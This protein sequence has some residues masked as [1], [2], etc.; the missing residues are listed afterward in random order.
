[1]IPSLVAGELKE[2]IVEYLATTFALTDDEAY[3]ALSDFLL[4]ENDGIFRGPFLRLRLP[5]V[6]APPGSDPGLEWT[7]PGFQP[8]VHQLLAWR[9][10]AGR[11]GAPAS[12]LITTGTG[13]GKSE[14]FL[15][16][17][18]D[19]CR[20]AKQ[21]GQHGIKALILYPMNALVVDQERRIAE[22]LSAPEL[23]AAGVTAGVWIGDDGTGSRH[24]VMSGEHLIN[25]QATLRANP[26]DIL[27][28]NYKM[29]DR[30]LTNENRQALWAKNTRPSSGPDWMQPLQ[31]L[32][33]DEFHT[34][35]GAQGTDVAMLLRRLGH[36]LGIASSTSPL[37]GVACIGTSATLGSAA[38]A[39][40]E[41]RQFAERVFGQDFDDASVIGEQR[42]TVDAV[43]PELDLAMS[44]PAPG[45][46][47]DLDPSDTD[48]L[49]M[50][51]TGIGFDDPQTVGDRLLKHPLTARLLHI[52][53]SSPRSWDDVVVTLAARTPEWSQAA[54][55]TP[56]LVADALERF[57]GLLSIAR[58]RTSSGSV[59]PL[60]AIEVQ[61][62]IREVT[63]ITRSIHRQARFHWADS[64]SGDPNAALELPAVYCTQCGRSGWLGVANR[65]AGTGDLAIERLDP[66]TAADPYVVALRDRDRSR[67]MVRASS[68]EPDVLWLDPD[69]GQV[70]HTDPQSRSIPVLVGGMTG[71][72][73]SGE[74]RDE[75]AK[76]QQCPSCG[77][78]DAM[79]FLG[80]RVT[81]LASVGITQM[82]GS[83]AVADDERRI[84]AF[85]D[86]VQDASHRAAFF[87]GRTHRFNL[88][89][90]LS[91]ALQTKGR[92]ALNDVASTVLTVADQDPKPADAVFSLIPPDLI[93]ED[94]LTDA[95]RHHGSPKAD[96]ARSAIE[97]RLSF[98]AVLEAG[99][100]S[101]LGRTLETT[102]T[103]VPEVLVTD[104]EW[105]HLVDFVTESLQANAG[106]LIVGQDALRPWIHGVIDR[107]R[108]RG[109]IH[110]P[111]LDR[112]V[113]TN[114]KRW[115][116]W[117]GADPI[118]PK[119]PKGISAPSFLSD[120]SSDEFDPIKGKQS[121]MTL[122]A[123][124]LLGVENQPAETV[125]RDL[126]NELTA[127]GIFE[128]R[129]SDKGSV[130]GI[131]QHRIEF[132]DVSPINGAHPQTELRCHVCAHRHYA[133][134]DR[135]DDWLG[136]PCMRSRCGGHLV[137]AALRSTNYYRRLYRGGQIRRVVAA[138]HT[139]LLTQRQ[140]EQIESGFKGGTSPDSPNV[141]AA[142]PTL[143]MGI[144][145]GDLSAVMLTA[146]PPTPANYIQRVGRAGRRTGNAFVTTFAEA[147]PRSQ[148]FMHEP[149]QMIAGDVTAPACFLD[150]I[151]IL[152]RQ[153]VAFL[154]DQAARRG[155]GV[156]PD[157]GEMPFRIGKL[158]SMGLEPDG[159]MTQLIAAGSDTEV[160]G[161]FV[162]LFG[163]HLDKKVILRLGKWA[164]NDLE[165]HIHSR[166]NRWIEQLNDLKRQRDRLRDR[167]KEL[168][169]L[170]N[171]S[172][173][174]KASL[175]RVTS[176]LRYVAGR[177]TGAQARDT[178]GAL[179]ALGIMP[180]Y[181]LFDDTVT[182]EVN[183]WQSNADYDP[184]S[185]GSRKF[186]TLNTE[187]QRAASVAIRE[188]APGNYFYV[189][190]H[191]VRI[192]ALDVGTE[193]EPSHA[194]WRI[195]PVCAWATK[196]VSVPLTKCDR[197]GTPHIADHGQIATVLPMRVV[198]STE[199][200]ATSRVADDT[201]ERDREFHEVRTTI[202][203]DP[204]D[205]EPGS[206]LLHGG[207]VT[208]GVEAARIATIRY[209]N[210]GLQAA[211][212]GI[213]R[214]MM[215]DGREV[216][217]NLFR[218]C[219]HCGGVYGIKGD[220]KDDTDPNHHRT[221]CKVRSGARKERWDHL[222]LV[223]ELTT[224]AVRIL[225]PIGDFESTER[226]QSFKAALML[227][228]RDSFGGD[229]SHLRILETSFP[230]ANNP[231]DR[232]R[233]VV[234]HDS[235][236]GGT[237]YL[238]RL[239][240]PVRLERILRRA[241]TLIAT[242][243]C[244]TRGRS[245]CHKCLYNSVGRREIP[246]V[247]RQHALDILDEI[248]RDW[249]L[250]PA[251]NNTITGINLSKVRQSELER[252]FKVLLHRWASANT[253]TITSSPDPLQAQHTRFILRFAS[254]AEWSIREQ[255]NLPQH[256]TI[257]DFY[258]ERLDRPGCQPIAIYLDG[259]EFHGVNPSDTD[260][261]AVKRHSLRT[262]GT[263]VWTLS[264]TDVDTA[265]KATASG[266][267]TSPVLPLPT[268]VRH[269][270]GQGL[271]QRM[272][273]DHPLRRIA[274]LAA[275][276]QLMLALE[277]PEATD[278]R[279]AAEV[280]AL[281]AMMKLPPI[282]VDDTALAINN[283][284]QRL[285]PTAS[286]VETTT[287]VVQ[288]DT[289]NGLPAA[290]M[291][292][293]STGADLTGVVLSLDTGL[294]ADKAR[295]TDWHHAANIFQHLDE[296]AVITTTR[297]FIP[298]TVVLAPPPA[299]NPEAH[300]PVLDN[301]YDPAA[302]SLTQAALD[303]GYHDVVIGE[304]AGDA[305]DTPIEAQWPKNKVGVVAVGVT[306]PSIG[307]GWTIRASDNW[308]TEELLDAL[309]AGGA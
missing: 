151:E 23:Q 105:L 93:W 70:R 54:V 98:D 245:G 160:V 241:R 20:W 306:A 232:V 234:V 181:T 242:C 219:R 53:S 27:L 192:D 223:H 262:A 78:R 7:P 217:A 45:V 5:F 122:W 143:E 235:V 146:V 88:R 13:S 189:N 250:E 49:A 135:F 261:D 172:E 64:A 12:T 269:H 9:R 251:P 186:E 28:T 278:W 118:A 200:E 166:L 216:A 277:H 86:S 147:D 303:A 102:G 73:K 246:M 116:I 140:R 294:S 309:H 273:A 209:L 154:V 183:L 30:L 130:W 282:W 224:E 222:V 14:A 168:K 1:M 167:E 21:Q 284:A 33:L 304:S 290:T 91:G 155:Q 142:T 285:E 31:Y 108:Q 197:C 296:S 111:F 99:V 121:W 61:V 128:R 247:S 57:V 286:S 255:V 6:D 214:Q 138:E 199:R 307:E 280:V 129:N 82:F 231:E 51:F 81:T 141:L 171:P 201:E 26:P 299:A 240:D 158:A 301:I 38:T 17:I 238:L 230:A 56:D 165:A 2:A 203:I 295:W 170:A 198:S 25:D 156:L 123:K 268:P 289:I 208:F 3:S 87:S 72:D 275:I 157:I 237:G 202:D 97:K 63:R 276:D 37:E 308:T 66:M 272:G 10:L 298:D 95:W 144:D 65:A 131:P 109:G 47:A 190:A 221:W 274:D 265:L 259:W 15:M 163:N 215:V 50:A 152:R 83:D 44:V 287:A 148:Y 177:I 127:L 236:P 139:G 103:A 179:E 212:A 92:V 174:E 42:Q 134:P 229:P 145:I 150:A 195:C 136:R 184:A 94:W 249:K 291:L 90:T 182:L 187:Y 79:R 271:T 204:L 67:T 253:V 305:D 114:G 211:R 22:L 69:D 77:N 59:R 264:Y 292:D 52:A 281:A 11:G 124:K 100:R 60:F 210:F 48:A 75:A 188:L 113:A 119:F 270:V 41:M 4:D 267:P 29:L 176:E 110:H 112:Y 162:S 258:A 175:G 106:Q 243:S 32:V 71:D 80:S 239:A 55:D 159:W 178:L 133:T 169:A 194:P 293:R 101:R 266:S 283:L 115:E 84:L 185:E 18:A 196:D 252:M 191:K 132:V 161:E 8:Y 68:N 153:Y 36:R 180:N 206:A 256:H 218:T 126:L 107:V 248:L 225:L 96:A 254:G 297:T 244:Q 205:I 125:L 34:Y 279:Q 193:N 104:D 43:C 24:S 257:P 220:F 207:D 62:W 39:T 226:V 35:D 74:A 76:Q 233:Y 85:T 213:N 263:R 120:A 164:E 89:A 46:V 173:E 58:G 137:S 227:G 260:D 302:L 149:E 117:G 300:G 16:P 288:W 40:V 19:H 228:L